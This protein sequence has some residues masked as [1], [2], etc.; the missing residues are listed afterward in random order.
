MNG[1]I[2]H[3]FPKGTDFTN[4][5]SKKLAR[6]ENKINYAKRNV[7]G[8]ISAV[9]FISKEKPN[10]ISIIEKLGVTNPYLDM[11]LYLNAIV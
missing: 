1:W 7:L 5:S 8:G 9:K 2:R 10:L 11:G 4:I 3:Y 6:V